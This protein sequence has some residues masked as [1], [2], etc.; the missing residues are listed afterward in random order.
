MILLIRSDICYLHRLEERQSVA[1]L[2]LFFFSSHH[3]FNK[4]FGICSGRGHLF[5]IQKQGAHAR[6]KEKVQVVR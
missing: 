5:D 2:H 4:G 6:K 1:V 3:F